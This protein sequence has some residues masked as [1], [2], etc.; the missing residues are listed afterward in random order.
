M[1]ER[2]VFTSKLGFVLAAAGSAVGLG[3]IWRF[4]YL[5]AEYGGGSFLLVYIILAVTFGFTLMIAEIGLGRKTKLSAIGAYKKLNKKY[6][7]EGVLTAAVPIII[8]PYYAVI[9]GWVLKYAVAFIVGNDIAASKDGY[10][11]SFITETW[12][13]LF[14]F[15]LCMVLVLLVILAGV[16]KGIE[17][18]S[19]ILMP[20]LV[21]LMIIVAVFVCTA[22]G[23][24]TGVKYY[25]VP[26]FKHF[27]AKTLLAA[28]GQLFYSL[29]LAMGIMI[30]YGSYMKDDDSLEGSVRQIEFFDTLIAVL[31]GMMIIP[32]VFAF[33]G[34][35]ETVLSSGPSLMFVTLPKAFASMHFGRW[36]G[37]C[38]FVMVFFAAMTSA[39]S[40]MEAVTSIFMDRFHISRLRAAG[41]TGAYSIFLGGF[42][43]LGYGPLA[44]FKVLGMQALDLMD[45]ISNSV[46]MPVVAI[47][48]CFFVGYVIKPEAIVEEVEKNGEKFAGKKMF[49]I[50]IK[51]IAPW[52]ILAVFVSSIAQ[53][54]GMFK[55]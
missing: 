33:S 30:T 2:S 50:I 43:S 52:F 28:V 36:I 3:N 23:A 49:I 38:F 1:K 6:A 12:E 51:Y 54:L 18:I 24:L 47:V 16:V 46:L 35:D 25:L 39:I 8:F 27:S 37:L 11:G 13:P 17:K 7:F 22:P 21:I 41:I 9:T 40:L 5:A 48:T 15:M 4:P 34:G 32:S 26:N 19:K 14:W 31:A 42:A 44:D 20:V 53:A 45:F 55:L 10:F 29:S